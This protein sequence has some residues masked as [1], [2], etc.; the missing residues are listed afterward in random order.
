MSST[1][2]ESPLRA[3]SM[4]F[5]STSFLSSA[6]WNE[7]ESNWSTAYGSAQTLQRSPAPLARGAP[8]LWAVKAE[9]GM[10][11][12]PESCWTTNSVQK[13]WTK[14]QGYLWSLG[15]TWSQGSSCT[16][17]PAPWI[18]LTKENFSQNF[19]GSELTLTALWKTAY[20]FSILIA[21]SKKDCT[22]C[23]TFCAAFLKV[24]TGLN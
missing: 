7:S 10:Q 12:Q 9:A 2:L 11:Q 19:S 17:K 8:A 14:C 23:F 21:S 20:V 3:E 1:S 6:C 22:V 24:R 13:L 18:K 4:S 15:A 16:D 5:I